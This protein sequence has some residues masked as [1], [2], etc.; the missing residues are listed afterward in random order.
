MVHCRYQTEV[1]EVGMRRNTIAV[2]ET[3]AGKTMIAV[4]L[5]KE[6]GLTM[7]SSG[8]KKYIIFLAPTV[9][10]VHQVCVLGYLFCC[11]QLG[12]RYI[13]YN[14]TYVLVF[15][16]ESNVSASFRRFICILKTWL[17]LLL[18]QF[19]VIKAHTDFEVAEYYGAM[20]V[21]DWSLKCWEKETSEHD[22]CLFFTK[23][24]YNYVY[25]LL[26]LALVAFDFCF[27][28]CYCCNL[29]HS[30]VFLVKH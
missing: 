4:M 15:S 14:Q 26:F 9:H 23:R 10:L 19:N 8:S 28:M 21:D 2:L 29:H 11:S 25:I 5:I 22:V 20:G 1:F 6:I 30:P 18:Q 27:L 12:N 16:F 17:L 24:P 3:G 13:M 7:K